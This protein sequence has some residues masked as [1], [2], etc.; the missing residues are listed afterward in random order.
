MPQIPFKEEHLIKKAP[1]HAVAIGSSTGGPRALEK[2]LSAFPQDLPAV[3]FIT[4]HMSAGF[5]ESLAARLDGKS[6][7]KVKEAAGGES[8]LKGHVYLA[9][10]GYHL[11]LER[12][13]VIA[14]S[15]AAPVQYVRP[16]IDVM[17][18]SLSEYFGANLIGVILTGMGQ[19]GTRGM[20]RIKEKG[21]QTIVQEPSTAVA[22]GMPNSVIKAGLADIIVPLNE[23][24]ATIARMLSK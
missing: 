20:A 21:G 2:I 7:L 14:L 6:S 19:D 23:I 13:G 9:R 4:Q 17:M 11:V 16:S 15:S 22:P 3:V 8:L 18:K 24:A 12:D 5:T 1:C 10:G